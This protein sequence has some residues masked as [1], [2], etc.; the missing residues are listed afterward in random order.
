MFWRG[1]ILVLGES[2]AIG[3]AAAV[4]HLL[5]ARRLRVPRPIVDL[6]LLVLLA[7]ATFRVDLWLPFAALGFGA[8]LGRAGEP[9]PS[10]P[11]AG[12]WLFVETP[13]LLIVTTAFAPNVFVDSLVAPSVIVAAG[14]GV[15]LAVTRSRTTGGRELVTGP[16]LLFLGL[17]LTVRLDP[18]MGPIGRYVV[19]FA[20]PAWVLLRL[21][22]TGLE[23]RDRRAA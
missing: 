2:G 10:L 20:L 9:A 5:L 23:R 19:D 6:L 14:L 22:M 1:P 13:F 17:T 12:R 21:V 15:F 11:A 3:I 7:E 4:V 18:R 8:A 16:G